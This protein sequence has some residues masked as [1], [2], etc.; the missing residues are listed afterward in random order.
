MMPAQMRMKAQAVAG[1]RVSFLERERE[2][3]R[4]RREGRTHVGEP[5]RKVALLK[6]LQAAV[7]HDQAED[8]LDAAAAEQERQDEAL[9]LPVL[10]NAVRDEGDAVG[11]HEL[12]NDGEGRGEDAED[13]GAGERRDLAELCEYGGRSGG[14]T[15]RR[16]GGGRGQ[17]RVLHVRGRDCSVFQK[18]ALARPS[19]AALPCP[20]LPA[21]REGGRV[22]RGR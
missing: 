13:D 8:E 1:R 22:G 6:L 12:E 16:G 15:G 10:R 2:K 17:R 9:Q 7:Q 20:E 18:L 21:G 3:E 4:A 5:H 19:D 14:R 11:R